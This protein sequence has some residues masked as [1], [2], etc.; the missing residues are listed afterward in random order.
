VLHDRFSAVQG[1]ILVHAPSAFTPELLNSL[2]DSMLSAISN[3]T[4]DIVI[5]DLGNT[6]YLD[7]EE[8]YALRRLAHMIEL[9]GPQLVLVG[10]NAGIVRYLI[11][12]NVDTSKLIISRD[13]EQALN[14]R[15]AKT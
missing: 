7:Q 15:K 9:M 10:L 12:A 3:Q 11:D 1:Q 4:C 2:A 8:F 14:M 5:L 6:D 13:I